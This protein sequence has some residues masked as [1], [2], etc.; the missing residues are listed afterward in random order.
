MT[1]PNHYVAV[2]GGAVSGA[3]AA[4]QLTKRGIKTVVFDQQTLPYGKIEDGLPK[5]HVKLRNKEEENIN[6]K[7]SH[8]LVTYIPNFKLG[9]DIT[10]EDIVNWGFSM[11]ILATGAWN[12]RPLPIEG[13]DD[14]LHK[15]FYYQN[16]F[17]Y[18]FNH[19]HEP[20][21]NGKKYEIV[22]D[23]IVIGGG[24][25]S[26]DVVKVLMIET[27]SAALQEKGHKIDIFK[28][29]K[30]INKT[31]EELGYTL[32]DLGVKGCTLYY[33]R[34]AKDMPLSP[35]QPSTP[36]EEIK[37]QAIRE[38]ILNTFQ[39]RFLFRF[40]ELHAPVNMIIE[41]DMVAGLVFQQTKIE[42]GKAVA[43]PDRE[44]EVRSPL[45]ISS[46]GSIPEL[47]DG[48]PAQGQV[49]KIADKETCQ[50][51]GYDNVFAVGNA[52]T[53]RGNIN[54]SLK[55]GKELL[56]KIMDGYLDWQEDKFQEY[57]RVS[58]S[59]IDNQLE[60]IMDQFK[61][62]NLLSPE[63]IAELDEKIKV[64]QDKAGYEGNFRD[65]VEKNLPKRLEDILEITH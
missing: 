26:I 4:L 27:V 50:I 7:L 49:F 25:A 22:D 34:R 48:I 1:L 9:R 42:D 20:N 43:L 38:K 24:L 58:E 6:E 63:K 47:I 61:G 60:T 44:V 35:S 23:A 12:D 56:P 16:P 46:I 59:N 5:W 62:D 13:I 2:I 54:E 32:D 40:K 11:V 3:E 30:G 41:D 53:G 19:Y 55:H 57:L 45:V 65:W 36:E 39:T 15:G 64:F 52:V 14:Y 18:W 33:R 21:Y 29:D 17:I 8:P 51:E 28:L 10:F 31:L 37:V